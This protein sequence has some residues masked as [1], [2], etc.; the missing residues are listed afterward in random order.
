MFPKKQDNLENVVGKD[1]GLEREKEGHTEEMSPPK[2]MLW[3]GDLHESCKC[4]HN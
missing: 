2:Y 3:E 1:F 4:G